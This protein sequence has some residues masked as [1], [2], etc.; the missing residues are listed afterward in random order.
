MSVRISA[1]SVVVRTAAFGEAL[2]AVLEESIGRWAAAVCRDEALTAVS[3]DSEAGR[4]AWSGHVR[5]AGVDPAHVV[6]FD[7]AGDPIATRDWLDV[8]RNGSESL[9][10]LRGHDRGAAASFV[11]VDR[12]AFH[13]HEIL[14]HSE[15]G[16]HFVR[17]K[18]SGILRQLTD[19]ELRDFNDPPP[20]AHCGEQF[21]CEHYNCAGEPLLAEGDLA[22][23]VPE[24]WIAFAREAG[25]SREDLRRLGSIRFGDGEYRLA[26]GAQ[27]DMRTLELVLLLNELR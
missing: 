18:K 1:G 10:W 11:V 21:G 27:S 26:P 14:S 8:E 15:S 23:S 4:V 12:P 2:A 16:L 20:C 7:A 22:A 6:E 25:V 17:E 9:A 19:A 5:D 24:Q 3:F 13:R